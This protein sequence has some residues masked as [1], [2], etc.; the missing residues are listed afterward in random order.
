[1][2]V[3]VFVPCPGVVC[4]AS[5]VAGMFFDLS[6]C[7]KFRQSWSG[8]NVSLRLVQI[9]N[10][11]FRNYSGTSGCDDTINAERLDRRLLPNQRLQIEREKE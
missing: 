3:E 6:W 7:I 11:F 8:A 1:M 2:V 4:D 5:F 9:M 10:I